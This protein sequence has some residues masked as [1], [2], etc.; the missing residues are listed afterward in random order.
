MSISSAKGLISSDIS[1]KGTKFYL[2]NI[3]LEVAFSLK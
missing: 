3:Q 1:A 2:P